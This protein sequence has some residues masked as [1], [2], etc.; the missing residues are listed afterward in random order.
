[1]L[2]LGT[3]LAQESPKNIIS[4]EKNGILLQEDNTQDKIKDNLLENNQETFNES[5]AN[6]NFE[7]VKENAIIIEDLTNNFNKWHGVLSSENGGLGWM[8]WGN[9]SFYLSKNLIS[10]N[11]SITSPT[12]NRLLKSITIGAKAP[13]IKN[14]D[15]DALRINRYNNKHFLRK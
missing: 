8:M 15:N 11:S 2:F 13:A 1:M 6:E 4:D 9:T 3:S 10:V 7:P 5:N 14:L 12:L